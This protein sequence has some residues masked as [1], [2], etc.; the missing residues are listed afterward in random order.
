MELQGNWTRALGYYDDIIQFH[1]EDILADDA[2]FRSAELLEEKL[3]NEQEALDHYKILL[4]EHPSSLYGHEARKRVR[5]L[6]G[7]KPPAP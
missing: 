6:R 7:E 4:L 2:L 3:L 5:I 1:T